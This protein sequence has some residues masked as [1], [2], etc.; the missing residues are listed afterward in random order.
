MVGKLAIPKEV[1]TMLTEFGKFCRKIR[2]DHGELLKDMA[3]KL[4]ISAAY[5]SAVEAGHRNIPSDWPEKI[6]QLYTLDIEQCVSLKKAVE[7]STT[8]FKIN[9]SEFSHHD[10][11]LIM[12]F[13]R[14]FKNLDEDAKNRI[15]SALRRKI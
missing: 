4:S 6:T 1:L 7:H 9:L 10:R 13:V 14:E 12:L 2:I 8:Q 3:N 15:K 5:L 11:D